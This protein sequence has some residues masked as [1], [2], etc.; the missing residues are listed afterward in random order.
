MRVT[1]GPSEFHVLHGDIEL[2]VPWTK[3]HSARYVYPEPDE[4]DEV[5]PYVACLALEV[6]GQELTVPSTAIEF[7]AFLKAVGERT[8]LIRLELSAK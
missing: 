5:R 8:E 3:V 4:E 1:F 7:R 6:E 2:R